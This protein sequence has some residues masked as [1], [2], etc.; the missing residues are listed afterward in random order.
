[1]AILSV[2]GVNMPSP[3][4]MK[5]NI[6][7]VSSSADRNASGYAVIDRVGVKRKLEMTWAH[8]T[9]QQLSSLLTAVGT[10]TFFTAQYPDPQTGTSRSMTCYCGDRAMGVLRMQNGVPVWTDVQMNWIER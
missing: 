4:A 7:D 10:N 2:N 8:L 6:F 1:M 9:A 3:S 5:V